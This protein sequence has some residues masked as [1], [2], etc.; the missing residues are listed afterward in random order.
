MQFL[1]LPDLCYNPFLKLL[2]ATGVEGLMETEG[3]LRAPLYLG[4][5]ALLILG[6]LILE[7][8]ALIRIATLAVMVGHRADGGLLTK[9][10]LHYVV[11]TDLRN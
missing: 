1:R 8:L 10:Y 11:H 3:M 6:L 9:K 4:K 2:L 5:Q 7:R